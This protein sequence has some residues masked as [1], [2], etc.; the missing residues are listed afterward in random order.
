MLHEAAAVGVEEHGAIAADGFR[1]KES[2]GGCQRRGVELIELQVGELRARAKSH[3][4]SI[5]R[6]YAGV[7]GV[8]IQ[9]ACTATGENDG[10]G[11]DFVTLAIGI[12]STCR[13]A[14]PWLRRMRSQA[15]VCSITGMPAARTARASA[16]SM[17]RPVES[18][19]ACRIRAR[20]CAAS[21]ARASSP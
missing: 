6:S 9:L 2:T 1:N 15:K 11:A 20:V 3:G 7:G 4:D 17:V 21:S 10:V 5:A 16:S 18:P 8:E 13:P 12:W 14:T 19:P